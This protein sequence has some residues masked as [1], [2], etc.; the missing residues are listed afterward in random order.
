M[1]TKAGT[2]ARE[3]GDSKSLELLAR[4]GLIS[5]GVV[6]LLIAWLALQLAWSKSGGGQETDQSGALK[7]L[8][9]Q[10][11]GK[12]LLWLVAVGLIALALWQASQSIWGCRDR[13]GASR[14]RKQV[15]SWAKAVMYAAM[16]VGAIVALGPGSP[17]SQ[18]QKKATSGVLAL[19]AGQV[20]V[21]AAAMMII[22]VGV[23]HVV[24]AVK[25]SFLEEI[26]TSLMP[27]SARKLVTGLGQAGYSAKGVALAL[28]GALLTYATVTF[29]PQNS[30]GL[31]GA[32][33]V[34][35]YQPFGSFLLT[36]IALGFAAFGLFGLA[37]ARYRRM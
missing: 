30:P 11:F 15:S 34:I 5:Y 1:I 18:L 36:A 20:I 2:M 27:A 29:D 24:R 14:V 13:E 8:A 10:P 37:Q 17:G 6:H 25:K 19:P 22:G 23:A 26:D 3:A 35:L 7:I 33:Q 4:G 12:V 9:H 16:G 31:D 28:V 21:V 32:L